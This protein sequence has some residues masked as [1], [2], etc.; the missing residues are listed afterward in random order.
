MLHIRAR[1][2]SALLVRGR[3]WPPNVMVDEVVA[4]DLAAYS[5]SCSF[6]RLALIESPK[7]RK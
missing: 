5:E 6:K 4:K 2:R 7:Y 3:G 1:W